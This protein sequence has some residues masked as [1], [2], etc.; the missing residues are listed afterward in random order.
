M[1]LC[2]LLL[3]PSECTSTGP[4][5]HFFVEVQVKKP[6]VDKG[7][8]RAGHLSLVVWMGLYDKRQKSGVN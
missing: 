2:I 7:G 6:M 8:R 1:E 5:T 4:V 3:H